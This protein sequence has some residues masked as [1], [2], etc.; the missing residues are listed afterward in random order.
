MW[1]FV[2]PWTV[3]HQAPLSMEFS[4]QESWSGLPF[5]S[6]GHL[7]N[8]GTEPASL[9][10]PALAG[11]FFTTEPP[12]C[13]KLTHWKR[14]WCWERLK[15]GE[16]G[17]GRGWDGWMASLTQWTWVWASSRTLWRT[18]WGAAV[19]GIAKSWTQLSDWTTPPGKPNKLTELILNSED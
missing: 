4:K 14:T 19:H 10:S 9:M 2:T 16:E 7:P 3:A 11:G 1:P 8:P 18:A 6:P 12:G 5:P 13:K 15:A 17:D